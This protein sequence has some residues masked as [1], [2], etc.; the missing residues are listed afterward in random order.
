M[1]SKPGQWLG[2]GRRISPGRSSAHLQ[3]SY[4]C[5][6]GCP[7]ALTSPKPGAPLGKDGRT[8]RLVPPKMH[9]APLLPVAPLLPLRL[10]HLLHF[11][12]FTDYKLCSEVLSLHTTTPP[13]KL[14]CLPCTR[15][16][17]TG[18]LRHRGNHCTAERGAWSELSSVQLQ[19]QTVGDTKW[20]GALNYTHHI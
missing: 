18:V 4:A 6:L 9:S 11:C 10:E 5:R 19:K 3:G 16:E 20:L 17:G 8:Q 2:K 1:Q 12:T 7:S 13:R 15:V 14:S